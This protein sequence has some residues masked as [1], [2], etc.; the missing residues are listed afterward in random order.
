MPQLAAAT[1]PHHCC[2]FAAIHCVKPFISIRVLLSFQMV[3]KGMPS[4][5]ILTVIMLFRS[6]THA[7][8]VSECIR[9]CDNTISNDFKQKCNSC[10]GSVEL[11]AQMCIKACGNTAFD[12]YRAICSRCTGRPPINFDMCSHACSNTIHSEFRHICDQCVGRVETSED[13][14]WKACRNTAHDQFRRICSRCPK[15]YRGDL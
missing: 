10:V 11:S 12:Q 9:A 6:T 7:L 4:T 14:C 5:L 8:S 13:M 15:K 3:L 2:L 1:K